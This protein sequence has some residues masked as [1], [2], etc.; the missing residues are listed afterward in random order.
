MCGYDPARPAGETLSSV[1]AVLE[2]FKKVGSVARAV[3][4]VVP[5]VFAALFSAVVVAA[6][7]VVVIVVVVAVR[8]AWWRVLP[9]VWSRCPFSPQ[10]LTFTIEMPPKGVQRATAVG[11]VGHR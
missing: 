8:F 2:W 6:A 9:V 5:F 4:L 1:K 10:P 11:C 3:R 7:V